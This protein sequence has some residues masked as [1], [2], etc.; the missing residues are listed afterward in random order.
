MTNQSHPTALKSLRLHMVGGMA[1]IAVFVLGVF[2]LAAAIKI[3]GA[4]IANGT[5][6]VDGNVKKVQHPTGGVVGE[7]RVK[8][9]MH[10]KAGDIVVRLDETVLKANLAIITKNLDESLA[11]RAREEAELGGATEIVFPQELLARA[12]EPTLSRVLSGERDLFQIRRQAL[13][14]RRIGFRRREAVGR[15]VTFTRCTD[16]AF[17]D[18]ETHCSPVITFCRD[19]V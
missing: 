1:L 18:E 15:A 10:V 19:R 8:D 5:L 13:Q 6:V 7:I 2:G 12:D 4:V 17:D 9:G 3:A 11:R 14:Y 16:I